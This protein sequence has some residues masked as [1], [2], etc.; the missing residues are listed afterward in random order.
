MAAKTERKKDKRKV[1]RPRYAFFMWLT[2]IILFPIIKFGYKAKIKRFKGLK[3]RN[4]VVLFNHQ[5]P[6]DQFFVLASFKRTIRLLSTEDVI[7][8][9]R[10]SHLLS[11]CYGIIPIKKHTTDFKAVME[12]LKVAKCGGNIAIAPEGNRTYSG[13][14][15]YIRPAIASLLLKMQLPVV[16]FKINGG[17]GVLPRWSDVKRKGKMS[18]EVT[19]VMEYD[20]YK[21]MGKDEF[22]ELIRSE[23]YVN[24]SDDGE[25]FYSK[26]SA[27]KLERV[28]Y[29]CPH[30]GFSEFL[31]EKDTVVCKS[32]G[33]KAKYNADKTFSGDFP[34]LTLL[35]W[36]KYQED[37]IVKSDFTAGGSPIFKDVAKVSR[38]I[39][40]VKK[41]PLYKNAEISLYTDKIVFRSGEVK[42]DLPFDK[43]GAV[44]VLG[45]NKLNVYTDDTVYQIKGNR[46]FNA[47]K[48][49]HFYNVYSQKRGGK[50]DDFFF[51]I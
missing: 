20:E 19:R 9:G 24:E 35:E 41:V 25:K 44:T 46:S 12:C 36:Y 11:F 6:F 38:V 26:K 29:V 14:T 1:L 3:G 10:I 30:C 50:T 5:T 8:N 16:F 43:I 37:V 32:C 31:S 2:R 28:L 17:Y 42:T 13:E 21:D 51:G 47:L 18:C 4:F 22:A 40:Y 7:S 33:R 15:S 48:Y 45:R 23:L 49:M 27:E 39:P 34:F